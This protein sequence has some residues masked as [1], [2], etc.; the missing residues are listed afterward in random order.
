MKKSSIILL[1]ICLMGS[2]II[3]GLSFHIVA[4]PLFSSPLLHCIMIGVIFGLINF[5]IALIF[6]KRYFTLKTDNTA[7][8]IKVEIDELTQ[9]LNRRAFDNYIATVDN[10]N[11]FSVI[12]IDIDNFRDFNNK[13]GH[14]IGDE[15]LVKVCNIIRS[16]VRSRDMVFRYGGEEIVLVL[17]ECCKDKALN[18][19]EQIRKSV[20]LLNNYP[21]PKITV[22]VG[23]A[24]NLTDGCT[25]EEITHA[26]DK[27][28]LAAKESGKNCVIDYSFKIA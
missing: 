2:G 4:M 20:N 25:L 11:L 10:N 9:L 17:E 14:K 6:L 21:Y 8:S 22:S 7:L 18:I 13:Y 1:F 27:A 16:C 12:F 28:L 5:V 19:G 26:A 15:V 3:Y 24:C 23:V